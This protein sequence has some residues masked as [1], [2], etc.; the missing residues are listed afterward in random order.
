[1]PDGSVRHGGGGRLRRG[2][3]LPH[4]RLDVTP[5]ARRQLGS[6]SKPPPL[7]WATSQ[8]CRFATAPYP[9]ENFGIVNNAISMCIAGLIPGGALLGGVLAG[10]YGTRTT[11]IIAGATQLVVTALLA[12]PLRMNITAATR[13]PHSSTGLSGDEVGALNLGTLVGATLTEMRSCPSAAVTPS[14]LRRPGLALGRMVQR[15]ARTPA[16]PV[17][18]KLRRSAYS[19]RR[20]PRT[21]H[22]RVRRRKVVA[23][24]TSLP[25]RRPRSRPDRRARSL[26]RERSRGQARPLHPGKREHRRD[27]RSAQRRARARVGTPGPSS[28]T[29]R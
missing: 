1:M 17:T 13:T 9:T 29:L 24:R 3:R 8:A 16:R 7:R 2:G 4:A 11:F 20:D 10:V 6:R 18:P 21:R 14:S 5:S 28:L 12:I 23:R 26:S 22:P 15:K 27:E 19:R 25:D